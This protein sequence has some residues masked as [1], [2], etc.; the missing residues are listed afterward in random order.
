MCLGCLIV[1]DN[2]QNILEESLSQTSLQLNMNSTDL[3]KSLLIS[4]FFSFSAI[5]MVN[6]KANIPELIQKDQL[7]ISVE[8]LLSSVDEILPDPIESDLRILLCFMC[9]GEMNEIEQFFSQ[10]SSRFTLIGNTYSGN[11]SFIIKT[12]LHRTT[13]KVIS[14]IFPRLHFL[15]LQIEFIPVS[16]HSLFSLNL[17]DYD[18][19]LL[20]YDR[21]RKAALNTM[22]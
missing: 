16:F 9:G 11:S 6:A 10:L 17:M 13:R 5:P 22:T 21:D 7:K 1:S 12:F 3:N 8:E 15:S 19:F 4:S 2:G 20:F 18:G 14:Q